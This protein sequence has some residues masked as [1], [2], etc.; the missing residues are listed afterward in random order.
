MIRDSRRGKFYA[1]PELVFSGNISPVLCLMNFVPLRV[2][3]LAMEDKFEYIGTSVL[4][5]EVSEACMCPTYIITITEED[6]DIESAK[7][8]KITI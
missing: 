5:D 4:F 7:V 1:T 3:Y 8:E 2:E 6:G